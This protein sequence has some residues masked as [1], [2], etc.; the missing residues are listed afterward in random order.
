M[1]KVM[2]FLVKRPGISIEELV[3][4]LMPATTHDHV[5]PAGWLI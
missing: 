3:D 1:L 4:Y 2:A 5:R